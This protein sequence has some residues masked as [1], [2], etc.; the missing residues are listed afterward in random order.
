MHI[1][2]TWPRPDA[3]H[4]TL[5]IPVP[6]TPVVDLLRPALRRLHAAAPDALRGAVACAEPVVASAAAASGAGLLVQ[7]ALPVATRLTRQSLDGARPTGKG[8]RV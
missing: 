4:R 8:G 1:E 2:L 7:L 5:T 6:R 3:A